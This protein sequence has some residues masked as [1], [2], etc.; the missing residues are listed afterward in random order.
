MHDMIGYYPSYFFVGCWS[1]ITPAICAG[2]FCFKVLLKIVSKISNISLLAVHLEECCVPGL[3]L[4][5]VG[6]RCGLLH[7]WI[8]HDLHPCVCYMAVVHYSGNLERGFWSLQEYSHYFKYFFLAENG[9]NCQPHFGFGRDSTKRKRSS[10]AV[11]IDTSLDIFWS[12][13]QISAT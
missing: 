8:L 11:K 2:V 1:V 5:M 9:Y 12:C 13:S 10:D 4:P 3:P 7:G 6:T